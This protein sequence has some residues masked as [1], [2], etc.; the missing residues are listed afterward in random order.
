MNLGMA[1]GLE[2]ASR[3]EKNSS[4]TRTIQYCL[5]SRMAVADIVDMLTSI[6]HIS[7]DE[8]R[9]RILPFKL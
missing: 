6:F 7:E 8:A 9:L 5:K 1:K 2:E 3:S 4:I